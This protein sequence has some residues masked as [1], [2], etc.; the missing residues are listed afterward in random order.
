MILQMLLVTPF[1]QRHESFS[2]DGREVLG[3]MSVCGQHSLWLEWQNHIPE[4]VFSC[5]PILCV[6]TAVSMM[7]QRSIYEAS[8]IRLRAANVSK[9]ASARDERGSRR[10]ISRYCSENRVCKV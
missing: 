8:E 3:S 6:Q 9:D 1:R 4:A 10:P 2:A 5:R 7:I